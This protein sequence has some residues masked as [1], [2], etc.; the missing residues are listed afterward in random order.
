M[1]RVLKQ[2][3]TQHHPAAASFFLLFDRPPS[4]D[5]DNVLESIRQIEPSRSIAPEAGQ[6][7]DTLL[8]FDGQMIVMLSVPA[9]VPADEIAQVIDHSVWAEDARERMRHHLG[10][11]VCRHMGAGEDATEQFAAALKLATALLRYGLVGLVDPDTGVA[12]PAAALPL[13]STAEALNQA[14][15]QIPVGIW[16]GFEQ[17]REPDGRVRFRSRGFHRWG[18]PDLAYLG[19]AGDADEVRGLFGGL[20]TYMRDSGTV[21]RAG[22]SAGGGDMLLRFEAV[23]DASD[24]GS[25]ILVQRVSQNA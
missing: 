8:Q 15:Q 3:E 13:A 17:W 18:K 23:K 16:T 10:H 22:E 24:A 6:S 7:S 21:F 19:D 12:I 4:F 5:V 1:D 25:V 9:P 11:I 20:L 2:A 14:R